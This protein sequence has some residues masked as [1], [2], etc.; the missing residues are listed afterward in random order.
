MYDYVPG[1]AAWMAS[2]LPF[3]GERGPEMRV[4]AVAH[5]DVPT[6]G[7]NDKVADLGDV[8]LVVVVEDDVVLGVIEG[9]AFADRDKTA[10]DVMKPGPSTFRPPVPVDELAQYLLDHDLQHTLIT[11]LDGRLIGVVRRE[12]LG[13]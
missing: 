8:P 9:D 6:C 7:L 2:F 12:D 4:G 1:K 10:A 13:V 5:R 11:T 3:E